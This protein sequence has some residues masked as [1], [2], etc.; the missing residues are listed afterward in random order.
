MSSDLFFHG[1]HA[2]NRGFNSIR[3]AEIQIS[4]NRDFH[5]PGVWTGGCCEEV[6]RREP[7]FLHLTRNMT[8]GEGGGNL[9]QALSLSVSPLL[10]LSLSS[11]RACARREKGTFVMK[12]TRGKP[13]SASANFVAP[14][15]FCSA[16]LP[17]TST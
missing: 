16:I 13:N 14:D 5:Y 9:S 11:S 7:E 8:F 2:R 12:K 3:L 6:K 15:L 17:P 10:T 1:V 4:A